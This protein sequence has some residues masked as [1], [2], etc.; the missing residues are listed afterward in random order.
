MSMKGQKTTAD[1]LDWFAVQSLYQRLERD[2]DYTFALLIHIGSYT[3][4]RISDLL[5]LKWEHFL[6]KDSYVI[7]EGKTGKHRTLYYHM[8]TKELV[9]RM[10]LVLQP[11]PEEYI[12]LNRF[13]EV[14]S[15]QFINRKLKAINIK[16]KLGIKYST[17]SFRKSFG[18]RIWSNNSNSEKSLVLLS[19]IFN[20]S[21][22]AITRR[23]LGIRE[24]EIKNVYLSL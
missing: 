21:S 13:G 14:L 5:G 12:F 1:Y 10:N 7:T 2:G 18:R 8:D 9:V 11:A 16:Y 6:G 23:Y 20:H 3:G 22:I 19:Q 17:H 4:L 15:Q 24:E